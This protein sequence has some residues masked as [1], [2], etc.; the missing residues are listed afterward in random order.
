MQKKILHLCLTLY[1]KINL[2]WIIDINEKPKIIKVL[3]ETLSN[4]GL[5]DITPTAQSIKVI[6]KIDNQ[7]LKLLPPKRPS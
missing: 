2:K 7:N 6:D 1:L 3:E 5:L 4:P